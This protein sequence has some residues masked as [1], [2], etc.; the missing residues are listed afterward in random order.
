MLSN[1][2][3]IAMAQRGLDLPTF[4]ATI[5]VENVS[6]GMTG[7]AFIAY[8]SSLCSRGFAGSQYALL[9]ALGLFTRN[10][11]SAASGWLAETVGW[12]WFFVVSALVA[13]PGMAL[14]GF[15]L[16]SGRFDEQA[17]A[18]PAQPTPQPPA[19]AA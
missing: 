8:L 6:G 16:L 7:V 3:Y 2:M 12:P 11:L 1:L 10:S 14:L 9:S 19:S 17:P 13:I 4:A 18:P 5:A 15:F